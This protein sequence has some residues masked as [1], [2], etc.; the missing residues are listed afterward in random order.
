MFTVNLK[1]CCLLF[2]WAYAC[3]RVCACWLCI[4]TET[5]AMLALCMCLCVR[6]FLGL[7]YVCDNLTEIRHFTWCSVALKLLFITLA[8]FGCFWLLLLYFVKFSEF[9]FNCGWQF[10]HFSENFLLQRRLAWTYRCVMAAAFATF[11]CW[12]AM[13]QLEKSMQRE[14]KPRQF[15]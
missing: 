7:V 1:G 6:E 15:S 13:P 5:S 11:V 2:G 4:V 8:S 14:H 10:W 3:K 12:L 9:V